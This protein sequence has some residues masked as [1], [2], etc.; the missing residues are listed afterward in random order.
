MLMKKYKFLLLL[1][2]L[3]LFTLSVF[4]IDVNGI[5]YSLNSWNNTAQV[6]KRTGG[7]YYD[8][9]IPATV[10]Y[11]GVVY[12]VTS[13]GEGA[14]EGSTGMTSITFPNSITS[15]LIRAFS[16]CTSLAA[17]HISDLASWCKIKFK[18][19]PLGLAQHL[20]L[21]GIEVKDLVV[22]D[23][24]DRIGDRAFAG[25]K[26]LTSVVITN[27]VTEIGNSSFSGCSELTELTLSNSLL[28]IGDFAFYNCSKLSSVKIPDQVTS[29]GSSAFS[30]CTNLTSINIPSSV[31]TIEGT[32]FYGCTKMNAVHIT[33]MKA[34]F[35]ISF[36]GSGA[37]P[38]S[39][40]H[41]L[42]L[43]GARI[44]SLYIPDYANSVNDYAFEGWNGTDVTFVEGATSIGNGAFYRCPN[45]TNVSIS[46]S[47]LSIGNSA[48][49]EC[50]KLK[51]VHLSNSIKTIGNTAFWKCNS[52]E[53]IF[54]PNSVTSLGIS[55]F[56]YCDK[57]ASVRLS[58]NLSVI[59]KYTFSDCP[60]TSIIIPNS[61]TSIEENAFYRCPL[62]SLTLSENLISIGENAFLLGRFSTLII[63]NSV[64]TIDRG[65]FELNDYLRTVVLGNQCE[66]IGETV[67]NNNDS[68]KD[69]YCYSDVVPNAELTAFNDRTTKNAT[70]HVPAKSLNDYKNTAPWSY[71]FEIV[72]LTD[73]DP[74]PSEITMVNSSRTKTHDYYNL[75]G[76][77]QSEPKKGVNIINGQK[78]IVK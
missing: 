77:R 31:K 16:G 68:L 6:V 74:I 8:V 63:P 40:A 35:E 70:L 48:F 19:N 41:N 76:V 15:V 57:L 28:K 65:A 18:S 38:L 37:N 11:E 50:P 3:N 34:W 10:E 46:S 14:F 73:D 21:N 24:V 4:S 52:L 25:Y 72:P 47:V 61:V 75:N 33:D 58:D 60:I 67:F 39:S 56:A 32:A 53:S 54:I 36:S 22:P 29:I 30:Y 43:N 69:F 44:I 12:S 71:F 55:A 59:E 17:V 42:Y 7:Y 1:V 27:G 64:K 51:Y 20:Y 62:K 13:I 26:A 5:G 49:Y 23:N 78:V 66:N 9:V 45:L 2:T